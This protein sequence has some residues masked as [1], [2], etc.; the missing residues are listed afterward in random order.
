LRNG[1]EIGRIIEFPQNT[2]EDDIFLIISKK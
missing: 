1:A 2:W